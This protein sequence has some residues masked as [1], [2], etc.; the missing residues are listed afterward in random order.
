MRWRIYIVL[1]LLAWLTVGCSIKRIHDDPR[2]F[3]GFRTDIQYVTQFET[4]VTDDKPLYHSPFYSP[5]R[6]YLVAAGSRGEFNSSQGKF[7]KRRE[8]RVSEIA[9]LPAGTRVKFVGVEVVSH[10][11]ETLGGDAVPYVQIL[12]GPYQGEEVCA[13]YL[14]SG[15]SAMVSVSK[16]RE[17]RVFSPRELFLLPVELP[18]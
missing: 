4:I 15:I 12:D 1:G 2:Y 6:L 8:R 17:V 11:S 3:G 18:R 9:R 5:S 7:I 10:T 14:C 16:G 13:F